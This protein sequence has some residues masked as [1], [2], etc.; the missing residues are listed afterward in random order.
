MAPSPES[1]NKAVDKYLIKELCDGV[2]LFYPDT[3]LIDKE[4]STNLD[5]EDYVYFKTRFSS[6]LVNGKVEKYKVKKIFE[7]NKKV[8]YINDHVNNSDIICQKDLN[9]EILG[10]NVL[11]GNG[12]VL[13][14]SLNLRLHQPEGGGG[15]SYRESILISDDVLTEIARNVIRDLNWSGVMMIELLYSQGRYYLVEINPRFWGSLSLTLFSGHDVVNNFV[16]F[17]FDRPLYK[18]TYRKVRARNLL[19]DLKWNI[20]NFS[21]INAHNLLI[22]PLQVFLKKETFDIESFSDIKP[23]FAQFYVR[24]LKSKY[25]KLNSYRRKYSRYINY[26]AP[27]INEFKK[28]ENYIFV[29][30]G[31]VNRSV[32]AEYYLRSKGYINVG[33]CG[34]LK[35]CNR[36][37]SFE[38]TQ[39]ANEIDLSLLGH[40]SKTFLDDDLENCNFV[41][42]DFECYEMARLKGVRH[43][44]L[45]S[46]CGVDDPHGKKNDVFNKTTQ[47]IINEIDKKI[48]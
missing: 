34:Y 22:S 21:L 38:I 16:N 4:A 9:G 11:A 6:N 47:L 23:T 24:A 46:N 3:K 28:D 10:L 5:F 31:N 45:F 18:D 27:V 39:A 36:L 35:N 13:S 20:K 42:M 15:S 32:F 26:K 41:A 12:E 43:L 44:T 8:N 30:K 14:L 48:I 25:F 7:F 40:K 1:Y 19:M 33:S 37:P 17:M 2:S 29:C